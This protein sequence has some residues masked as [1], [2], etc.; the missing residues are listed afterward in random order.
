M[1]ERAGK[2]KE[3]WESQGTQG[4]LP[5]GSVERNILDE[6]EMQEGQT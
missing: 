5:E 4:C 2:Y 6:W 1:G 3:V